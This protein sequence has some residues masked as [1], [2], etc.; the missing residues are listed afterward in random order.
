MKPSIARSVAFEM[1]SESWQDDA[2]CARHDPEIFFPTT[3]MSGSRPSILAQQAIAIC[4]NE[5][6]VRDE[7]LAYALRNNERSGI[8]GGMTTKERDIL[9]RR[10]GRRA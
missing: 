4:E 10:N 7:C 3:E 9:K 8:W 1:S 2:A 5:C 6:K